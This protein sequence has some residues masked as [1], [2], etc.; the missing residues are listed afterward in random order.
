[1]Q[2]RL[3]PRRTSTLFGDP[4]PAQG[5]LPKARG[6]SLTALVW[7]TV[8]AALLLRVGYAVGSQVVDEIAGDINEYVHYAQN[9]LLHGV[10]SS[11]PP[12]S[13]AVP[14]PDTFRPPGYPLFLASAMASAGSSW[15]AVAKAMQ[16]ALSTATVLLTILIAREWMRPVFAVAAG[17]LIAIWPHLVVF[18]ST[19]LSETL[20]GFAL[21]LAV[22]LA[23][24]AERTRRRTVAACAGLAFGAAC[25]VNTVVALLPVALLL[26]L[27]CRKQGRTA[28]PFLAG[29]LALPLVWFALAPPSATA[30]APSSF[31]RLAMNFVQGSWPQ[32]HAAWRTRHNNEIS[33]DIL[34]AIN[35]EVDLMA[36]SPADGFT[37]V[38]QRVA[39]DPRS[40]TTWYLL[41]K[42]YA[43]WGWSIQVGWRDIYFLQTLRSPYERQPI[44]MASMALVK[45]LNPLVFAA[46]IISIGLC[47]I[48]VRRCR[49][50]PFALLTC[51]ACFLYFTSLHA[52]LQAEPRYGIP[53]R[54]FE[55]LLAVSLAAAIQDWLRRKRLRDGSHRRKF[56]GRQVPP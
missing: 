1:M 25:L 10:Y 48:Q 55:I 31:D 28:G 44:P 7:L 43:L 3:R 32:Y 11:T 19:L 53:Y 5:E 54:A 29:F 46:A 24:V 37:A 14:V 30:A 8:V 18:A 21:A 36:A 6:R 35:A 26:L 20:F 52:V 56:Y 13:G 34:S 9:I 23:V 33:R 12:A 15:I 41:E 47:L 40:Y 2:E 51:A 22:W 39:A 16:I 38:G 50:L 49:T 27:A 17:A 4:D 45:K 42:P